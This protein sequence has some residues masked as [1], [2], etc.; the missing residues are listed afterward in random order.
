MGRRP[1]AVLSALLL[2]VTTVLVAGEARPESPDL[3]PLRGKHSVLVETRDGKR[4]GG[5]P[6]GILV[7]TLLLRHDKKMLRIP[8]NE[9]VRVWEKRRDRLG[10]TA[11]FA[12]VGIVGGAILSATQQDCPDCG[13]ESNGVLRD[14]LEEGA[15]MAGEGLLFELINGYW[16]PLVP[17]P[18][19]EER[20]A[21]RNQR[22]G[23]SL[24][25]QLAHTFQAD[26]GGTFPGGVLGGWENDLGADSWGVEYSV[27][28]LASRTFQGVSDAG[29][30]FT[31]VQHDR[32]TYGG[33]QLRW[34]STQPGVKP[35]AL[36][37]LGTYFHQRTIIVDFATPSGPSRERFR[38]E[39]ERLFGLNGGVGI[40]WGRVG[41]HP[42]AG[43]RFHCTFPDHLRALTIAA[44]VDFQ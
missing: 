23:L 21:S 3:L 35:S 36:F 33:T 24:H 30:A 31:E 7:D 27:V 2:A 17:V 5:E 40:T 42:A 28:S 38:V 18:T 41:F 4:R 22:W 32:W 9:V 1:W 34:R 8:A 13:P 39:D 10:A 20:S 12:A 11:R 25:G 44:G 37:G 14:A 29:D 16:S 26:R 19:A 6:I 43:V 15:W